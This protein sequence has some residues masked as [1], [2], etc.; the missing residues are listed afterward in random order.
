MH[1]GDGDEGHGH[2]TGTAQGS[3]GVLAVLTDVHGD[4]MLLN[5]LA[6]KTTTA[7]GD[8]LGTRGVDGST[9]FDL[10][11]GAHIAVRMLGAVLLNV[12]GGK[13]AR[14]VHWNRGLGRTGA[15]GQNG[16][17]NGGRCSGL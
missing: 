4:A 7:N 17:R 2:R 10:H 6:Q 13:A 11:R 15:G 14:I 16:G 12:R 9:L 1:I 3:Q 8:A 5:V